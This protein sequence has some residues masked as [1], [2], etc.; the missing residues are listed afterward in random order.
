MKDYVKPTIEIVELRPEER[1]ARCREHYCGPNWIVDV[2]ASLLGLC[3]PCKKSWSG[4][5]HC[6]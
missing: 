2:L 5:Q 6:S 4:S 3:S 1:L